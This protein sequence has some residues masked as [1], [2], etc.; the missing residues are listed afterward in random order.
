DPRCR[1][2]Y[3]AAGGLAL[4]KH[5]DALAADWFRRGI[6]RL[7]PDPDLNAGLARAYYGSDRKQMTA[8]PDA[9]P[10]ENPRHPDAPPPRAEHEIDGEDYAGAR[11]SL[12]RVLAVDAGEP[13]AWAFNAVLAHLQNDAAGEDRARGRALAPWP[14]NPEVD[15]LIGRK[16]SEKYR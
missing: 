2:A 8:A 1:P 14:A 7:G 3:L 15:W 12:E 10:P 9:A 11:K 6:E 13:R 16:L 4:A 5:D